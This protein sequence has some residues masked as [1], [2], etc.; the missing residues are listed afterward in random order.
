MTEVPLTPDAPDEMLMPAIAT[1]DLRAFG[2]LFRRRR[3]D[4]YRFALHMTGSPSTAEDVAQ[5]VF[6]TLMR[7]PTRYDPARGTVAAW[8]CGIA[9]N[10]VRRRFERERGHQP[11]MDDETGQEAAIPPVVEDP[12]GDMSRAERI[13]SLKRAILSIP[14]R[15]R[16]VVVMCDLQE[17]S[18]ADAAGALECAVGTIRSRLHRGRALLALKVVAA[19]QP[20]AVRVRRGGS[21]H[22]RCFA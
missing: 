15:Y 21:G 3:G 2:E 16:E 19:E 4:V 13:E 1:G 12:L 5:D 11:L 17:M 20:D 14:L 8:L 9:R 6:L 18:Y 22:K 10:V 7:E